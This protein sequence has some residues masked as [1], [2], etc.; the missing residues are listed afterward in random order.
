MPTL[1]T[2]DEVASV[3]RVTP[4]TIRRYAEEGRLQRIHVGDKLVRYEAANVV[5][6]LGGDPH[7]HEPAVN[8]PVGKAADHD[9]QAE[10]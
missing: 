2:T 6:L 7:D 1:L 4:R 3:L 5:R 8:G 10:P 9:G